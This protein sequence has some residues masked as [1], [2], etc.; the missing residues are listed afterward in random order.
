[1]IRIGII[2]KKSFV[3]CVS[4]LA[5]GVFLEMLTYFKVVSN[6]FEFFVGKEI[7]NLYWSIVLIDW[8]NKTKLVPASFLELL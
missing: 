5:G 8:D 3:A 1:M 7:Q 2:C 6:I 4:Q